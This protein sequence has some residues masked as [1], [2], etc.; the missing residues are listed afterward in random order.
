LFVLFGRAGEG[1][2]GLVHV[3]QVRREACAFLAQ[4]LGNFRLVPDCGVF[5]LAAY[6]FEPLFLLV[7]LK[8]T[9]SR[10]TCV[11]RVQ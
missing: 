7:V 8:E 4:F 11:P 10:K 6:F 5:E 2:G 3:D 1:A 9:P